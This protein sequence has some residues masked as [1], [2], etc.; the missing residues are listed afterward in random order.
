M[1]HLII[2]GHPPS[3][4]NAYFNLPKRG[5]SLADAGRKYL[6]ETVGHLQRAYRREMMFFEKNAPYLVLAYM[7]FDQ[8]ENAGYPKTAENRYKK[9]DG[10]NFTKLL[11]DA[12]KSAGGVDD[13]QTLAFFWWKKQGLPERAELWVWNL[14][15]EGTPFD[16]A[17]RT[18]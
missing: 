13:S 16:D 6:L 15:K 17:L 9:F 10:N 3:A 11:E 14:D 5:R 12:L 2:P 8:I 1:I 18:L 7:F 4:N